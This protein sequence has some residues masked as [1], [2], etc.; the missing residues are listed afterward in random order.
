LF[1]GVGANPKFG[2]HS[3]AFRDSSF[4]VSVISSIAASLLIGSAVPIT[5]KYCHCHCFL[6]E[7]QSKKVGGRK[8]G[9]LVILKKRECIG[10]SLE[11]CNATSK[12]LCD[13][14]SDDGVPSIFWDRGKIWRRAEGASP[15]NVVVGL[16]RLSRYQRAKERA[17]DR[18]KRGQSPK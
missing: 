6:L 2:R 16:L 17:K 10:D 9:P 4:T 12:I 18:M 15:L 3:L 7:L 11:K 1:V 13:W 8:S 5:C 14:I